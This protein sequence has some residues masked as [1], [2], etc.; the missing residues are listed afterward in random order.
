VSRLEILAPQDGDAI[1]IGDLYRKGKSSMMDSV[2]YLIEA[3]QRL[4]AKKDSLDHGQWLPW[5]EANA[6]TLG[7]NSPRTAQLLMRGAEKAKSTS[8]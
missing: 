7:F 3:G 2:R 8:H 4:G 5:L 6:D 1:Q